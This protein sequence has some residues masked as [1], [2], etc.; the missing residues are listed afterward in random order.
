[1]SG[2]VAA[3]VAKSAVRFKLVLLFPASK[4]LWVNTNLFGG[5][6]YGVEC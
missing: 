4:G 2:V 5:L 3:L 6:I 1:M